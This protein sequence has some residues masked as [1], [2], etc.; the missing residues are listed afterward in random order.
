MPNK[1]DALLIIIGDRNSKCGQYDVAYGEDS[2][3][4][5]FVH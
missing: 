3:M 4:N 5:L 2:G 1:S